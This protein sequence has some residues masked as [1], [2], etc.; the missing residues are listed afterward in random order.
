MVMIK[1][2]A[3]ELIERVVEAEA[4]KTVQFNDK[5]SY[6]IIAKD[7]TTTILAPDTESN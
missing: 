2:I 7:D 5:D 1:L 6:R 3:S 4:V